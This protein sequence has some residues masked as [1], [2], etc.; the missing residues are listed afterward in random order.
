MKRR[1]LLQLP[2]A[3]ALV[4]FAPEPKTARVDRVPRVHFPATGTVVVLNGVKYRLPQ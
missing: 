4:K 1:Q 3:A 2:L